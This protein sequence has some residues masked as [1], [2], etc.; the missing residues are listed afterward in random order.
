MQLEQ[1][2]FETLDSTNNWAKSHAVEFDHSAMTLI[3]A[4]EQTGGRGRFKRRWES[5]KGQN[6]YATYC[7]FVEENFSDI[8]HI[9]QVMSLSASKILEALGCKP[10]IKWPNDVLLEKK[11]IVGILCETV[12][13]EQQ[14]CII[15]GIGLNVNMPLELLQKIDRPAISLKAI[16]KVEFDVNFV[17]RLLSEQ[18]LSDI[19]NFLQAGFGSFFQEYTKRFIF[20]K[21]EK[22]RFHDNEKIVDGQFES[23][24]ED[25]SIALILPDGHL[26]VFHTGEFVAL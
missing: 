14:R 20:K 12:T 10:Q 25:G 24:N 3:S 22:V 13:V 16:C 23:V 6:I 11:K 4:D 19:D 2:H 21:G 1:F 26:K 18:F 8:G 15:C 5:P 9:P 17:L 7:F